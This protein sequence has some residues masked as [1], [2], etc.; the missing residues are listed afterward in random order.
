L[1]N[2][3]WFGS[4]SILPQSLNTSVMTGVST[5]LK[6]ES[7]LLMLILYLYMPWFN[8]FERLYFDVLLFS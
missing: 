7:L 8:V 6:R 1:C 3:G 4:Q 2:P 5:I